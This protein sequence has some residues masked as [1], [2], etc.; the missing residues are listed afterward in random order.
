MATFKAKRFYESPEHT[1]AVAVALP[2]IN[3]IVVI[4]R[5]YTR[6]KQQWT[7]QIDDWLTVPALVR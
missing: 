1:F 3:A 5:F 6:R 4:L 2:V 7:L